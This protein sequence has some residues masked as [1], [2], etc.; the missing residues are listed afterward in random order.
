MIEKYF[1]IVNPNAGG[2]QAKKDWPKIQELLRIK[3]LDFDYSLTSH[4]RHAIKLSMNALKAGYRKLIAVGG[5]GTI[6][7]IVNGIME[8]SIAKT[9][10]RLGVIMIGTGNDWGRMFNIPNDYEKAIDLI[11]K[12][13]YF[14]QDV[15]K[16]EYY[17]QDQKQSRYFINTAGLGFDAMVVEHANKA[18]DMGKSSKFSYI[19]TLLKT[20]MKYK[21]LDVNI[22]LSG[23]PLQG[24]QLFTMSIGIGKYSGG[25]MMQVPDALPDDGFFDIMI[26]NQIRKGKIIR[27]IKK[28]YDGNIGKIKEVQ[29]LRT[30]QIEVQSQDLLLLQ[31]DGESL[32]HA[33]F[34]FQVAQEQLNVIVK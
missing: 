14:S 1:V 26:V 17:L 8:S 19:L 25:G 28:L 13:H 10:I 5:D 21:K 27:K 4:Q 24:S 12:E 6:N 33:P 20:L 29:L 22:Q 7:E 18:K 15:G 23:R 2:G 9:D 34:L 30:D 31:V 11:I 16:V 3:N 32:G